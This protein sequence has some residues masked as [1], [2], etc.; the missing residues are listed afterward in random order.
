LPAATLRIGPE[1]AWMLEYYPMR[2]LRE[3]PDGWFEAAMT[4]ASEEWMARLVLGFGSAVTV[5]EPAA[6]AERVRASARAALG[7]YADAG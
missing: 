2:V 1:A 7:A 5:L 4:Y 6:L 3:L